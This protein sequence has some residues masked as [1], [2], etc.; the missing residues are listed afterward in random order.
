VAAPGQADVGAV[1]AVIAVQPGQVQA[2][3]R[4]LR[5]S[6]ASPRR[7]ASSSP[8]WGGSTRDSSAR[9]S[10]RDSGA[11]SARVPRGCLTPLGG[12]PL[13][14]PGGV[15]QERLGLLRGQPLRRVGGA[16]VR[17]A[18][19]DLDAAVRNTGPAWRLAVSLA[20]IRAAAV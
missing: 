13:A 16:Q 8:V 17:A 4:A 11:S 18:E 2:D 10:P 12:E 9:V 5:R 7:A 19:V 3:P 20:S 6:S 1:P 14:F 15:L